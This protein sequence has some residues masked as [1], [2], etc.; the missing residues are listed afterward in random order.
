MTTTKQ[1]ITLM[2]T[3][4]IDSNIQAKI[5]FC[6]VVLTKKR[7]KV[8]MQATVVVPTEKSNKIYFIRKGRKI[9]LL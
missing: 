4:V 5:M 2:Q 6:N 9:N 1:N 7:P 3:E 8:A